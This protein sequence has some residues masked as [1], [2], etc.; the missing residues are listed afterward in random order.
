MTVTRWHLISCLITGLTGM[1]L[2][3]FFGQLSI[4]QTAVYTR[5]Y[6][7][8]EGE[9]YKNNVLWLA[10]GTDIKQE[11]VPRY[12]GLHRITIF[13]TPWPQLDQDVALR[14]QLKQD[15]SSQDSMRQLITTV[16][17]ES[18]G[19]GRFWPFEF[20]PVGDAVGQQ[21]CLVL[22]ADASQKEWLV[23]VRVSAVDVYPDGKVYYVKPEEPPPTVKSQSPAPFRLFLPSV[24][25]T[26]TTRNI[27]IG[28]ELFYA[29][30]PLSI[31]QALL[32]HLAANK[33]YFWGS[34]FF[35]ISLLILYMASMIWLVRLMLK[36]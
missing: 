9:L 27:D 28:F 7:L 11:F 23:G 8:G 34:Q 1:V 33:P 30:Q 25:R 15:C 10:S 13:L 5:F 3:L 16:S 2:W 36:I 32:V 21:I 24:S 14:L 4:F 26:L 29:D 35:Y 6:G 22:T 19:E 31:I 18:L 12:P 17:K 20:E